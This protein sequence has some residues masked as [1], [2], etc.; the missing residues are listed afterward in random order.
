M[1]VIY[2]TLIFCDYFP[3]KIYVA[4]FL[5]EQWVSLITLLLSQVLAQF[6]MCKISICNDLRNTHYLYLSITLRNCPLCYSHSNHSTQPLNSTCL[7]PRH[8]DALSCTG[9]S[10]GF[11]IPAWSS[12]INLVLCWLSDQFHLVAS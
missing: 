10:S 12:Q 11:W 1:T 8:S 6:L 2:S 3:I 4:S 9:K 5:F 7:N